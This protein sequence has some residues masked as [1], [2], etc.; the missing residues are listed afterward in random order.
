MNFLNVRYL[1]IPFIVSQRLLAF[2]ILS[3]VRLLEV[4]TR[5]HGKYPIFSDNYI[6]KSPLKVENLK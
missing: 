2:Q 3:I 4:L 1:P 5:N 6:K